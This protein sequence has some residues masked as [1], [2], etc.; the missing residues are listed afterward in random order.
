MTTA[1][2]PSSD[3]P[4]RTSAVVDAWEKGVV[5]SSD[6]GIVELYGKRETCLVVTVLPW[7]TG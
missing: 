1:R 6:A 5:M 4:A 3:A 2:T 7:V